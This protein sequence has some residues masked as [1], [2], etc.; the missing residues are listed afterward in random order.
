MGKLALVQWGGF[1][2]DTFAKRPPL[3]KVPLKAEKSG[4][5]SRRGGWWE[6]DNG[7]WVPESN[8]A[9]GVLFFRGKVKGPSTLK[10]GK[11]FFTG[12][13]GNDIKGGGWVFWGSILDPLY[14][15]R[16]ESRW[17]RGELHHSRVGKEM[18]EFQ[19]GLCDAEGPSNSDLA[20]GKRELTL[21]KGTC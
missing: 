19:E 5:Q 11:H 12:R 4:R 13:G 7:G 1:H 17:K 3:T 14:R 18:G 21:K 2:S 9:R 15:S 6:A 8:S 10:K 20:M 16:E